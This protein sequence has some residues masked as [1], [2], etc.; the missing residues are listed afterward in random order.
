MRHTHRCQWCDR[1]YPGVTDL[2]EG[3]DEYGH[4]RSACGCPVTDECPGCSVHGACERCGQAPA[5]DD[6]EMTLC[7]NC[8]D[9]TEDA[10]NEAAYERMLSDYYGG[11]GP[12][13]DKERADVD[14]MNQVRR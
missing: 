9:Q 4:D 3:Q 14:A 13:S 7:A 10:R 8:A 12:Q 6:R 5:G 11:G 2:I 1:D